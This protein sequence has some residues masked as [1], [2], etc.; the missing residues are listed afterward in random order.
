MINNDTVESKPFYFPL[1]PAHHA[2]RYT[3]ILLSIDINHLEYNIQ[4]LLQIMYRSINIYMH[5]CR[6]NFLKVQTRHAR[7]NEY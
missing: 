3:I 2:E 7:E 6:Y 1:L 4:I 5:L